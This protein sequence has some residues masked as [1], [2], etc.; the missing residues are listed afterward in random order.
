[1]G[2]RARGLRLGR[3]AVNAGRREGG[4]ER[5]NNIRRE[6]QRVTQSSRETGNGVPITKYQQRKWHCYR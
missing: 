1:M 2:G 5:G 3:Q 6:H 4:R